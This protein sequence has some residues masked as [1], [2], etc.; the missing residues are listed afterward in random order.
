MNGKTILIVDSN[1]ADAEALSAKLLGEGYE[2]LAAND[3]AEAVGTVRT[4]KIDLMLLNTTFPPDVAHG[5]GVMQD[6]FTILDWLRRLE[7]A[8][9]LRTIMITADDASQ[10]AARARASGAIGLFQE[11]INCDALL[12]L[13]RQTL[14]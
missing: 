3:G 1:T 2:V 11:P 6:G 14:G 12:G 13:I 4:R 9:G 8:Q 10:H 5:G 7:E